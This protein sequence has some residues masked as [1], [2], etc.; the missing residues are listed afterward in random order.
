METLKKVNNPLASLMNDSL[1]SPDKSKR[2]A[3]EDKLL[4]KI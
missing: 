3:A 1:L 4:Q 2:T